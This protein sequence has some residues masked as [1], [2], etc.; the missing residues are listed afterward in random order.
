MLPAVADRLTSVWFRVLRS[1]KV[2]GHENTA[3]L[4]RTWSTVRAAFL[5]TFD[6]S[7]RQ[8]VPI[9]RQRQASVERL[10]KIA[11]GCIASAVPLLSD[12]GE[13]EDLDNAYRS[14]VQMVKQEIDDK[15]R[16]KAQEFC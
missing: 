4:S 10:V 1:N 7:L 5:Q 8:I 15:I 6:G 13:F 2:R 9:Q 11:R 14:I 12:G 16:D 3:E